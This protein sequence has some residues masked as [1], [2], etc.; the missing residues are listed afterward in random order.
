[1]P[2]CG[3]EWGRRMFKKIGIVAVILVIAA[4]L[5]AGLAPGL[6]L[7]AGDIA[8]VSS[9]ATSQF[10]SSLAFSVQA[11]S[12]ANIVDIRLHFSVE[13][14]SFAKVVTE[15]KL[16]F[17]SSNSVTAAYTWDMRQS[18]GLPTGTVVDFWWS[19]TD[20]AGKSLTTSAQKVSFDDTRFTWRL[21]LIHI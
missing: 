19:I 17:S 8:V 16:G 20:A 12:G 13:R 15:E 21:S 6:S 1:M 18:G 5:L 3:L 9:T 11:T 7:A 14:D 10:P 4:S 2:F